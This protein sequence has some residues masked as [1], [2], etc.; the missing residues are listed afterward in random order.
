MSVWTSSNSDDDRDLDLD[1]D[2]L[3]RDADPVYAEA[4]TATRSSGRARTGQAAAGAGRAGLKLLGAIP[5]TVLLV[6]LGVVAYILIGMAVVYKIDDDPAWR[7]I[8]QVRGGSAAVDMAAGLIRREVQINGWTPNDPPFYPGW[9]LDN[10]PN[11][12][13]GIL[14]AV[15]RFTDQLRQY[16]GRNRRSSA[17]DADL[18]QAYGKLSIDPRRW[19]YDITQS[20][21]PTVP[22]E[23][24]FMQ[25]RDLLITYNQRVASG[26]AFFE[27]R[28]DNLIDTLGQ[29]RNDLG[30]AAAQIENFN[31]GEAVPFGQDRDARPARDFEIYYRNKGR[32]YGYFMLFEALETDFAQVLADR[33][34]QSVWDDMMDNLRIAAL[35]QPF[36]TLS[37][38]LDGHFWPNHL[39]TQG[40]YILRARVQVAEV[41]DILAK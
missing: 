28:A 2:N 5:L 12:Q 38:D 9:Y 20:W 31:A 4:P 17:E 15:Q 1:L 27:P 32:L 24:E 16:V 14:Y 39:A 23:E 41:M 8:E 7:P 13:A 22:A 30:S 36:M 19:V 25:A 37:G 35:L 6:V 29:L 18:A 11:F 40:F 26:E 3:T 33:G 10:M 21:I 34:A